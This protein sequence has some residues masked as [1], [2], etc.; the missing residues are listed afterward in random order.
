MGDESPGSALVGVVCAIDGRPLVDQVALGGFPD[1]AVDESPGRVLVGIALFTGIR[2]PAVKTDSTKFLQEWMM[3][4]PAAVLPGLSSL[5]ID[6][7]LRTGD[8]ALGGA[9]GTG[10][11]LSL[12]CSRG[13]ASEVEYIANS[14]SREALVSDQDVGLTSLICRTL[15]PVCESP[16]DGGPSTRHA[17]M[18]R[19]ASD[20]ER[21]VN[22]R[23]LQGLAL[24]LQHLAL[25][26]LRSRES[27]GPAC[28]RGTCSSQ[29][30]AAPPPPLGRGGRIVGELA[31]PV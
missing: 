18:R 27:L 23:L 13:K 20:E 2:R 14:R 29:A 31:P 30:L 7:L 1:N 19:G 5:R 9:R 6:A 4:R 21:S 17:D 11:Y 16:A 24:F 10:H 8:D 28:P 3:S 22:A 15:G 12:V 26:E 25:A